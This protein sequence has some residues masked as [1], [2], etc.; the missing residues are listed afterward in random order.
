MRLTLFTKSDQLVAEIED[1]GVGF[2]VEAAFRA[3]YQ[4]GSFG[5]LSM[6]ERAEFAGGILHIESEPGNG[7][8][9]MV[10]LPLQPAEQEAAQ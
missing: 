3:S 9:V 1:D 6:Q 5:L 2:D 7:T 10:R 4:G 8:V